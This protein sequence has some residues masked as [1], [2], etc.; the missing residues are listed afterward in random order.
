MN[1][2]LL[3]SAFFYLR[4]ILA[5]PQTIDI[6]NANIYLINLKHRKDKL[7]ASTVQ[8]EL[9]GLKFTVIDAVN[10]NYL[11]T[12]EYNENYPKQ[13]QSLTGI[14]G[15]KAD[16]NSIKFTPNT[17][18]HVGCWLSHL[19]A[20]KQILKQFDDR[21]SLILEDDFI[22]DGNVIELVNRYLAQL[23]KNHEWDL[24]H[25]G[26]CDS[27]EKCKYFLNENE[28]ICYTEERVFCT[29]AY[30]VKNKA[31]AKKL[32]N[33]GNRELPVLA[34]FFFE[35]AD[36]KRY[37]VFPHIFKQ[38]KNIEADIKSEGGIHEELL[39]NSLELIVNNL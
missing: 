12:F 17:P 29:H 1:S 27:K 24:L 34:D 11:N 8:L 3:L 21:I 26:H 20:L 16:L 18:A 32:F 7:Y 5:V 19:K 2:F 25:A 15:L 22:A 6:R 37:M 39:N 38:R 9:L 10:G 14:E 4:N 35:T 36:L 30:I 28:S 23:E 31:A 13:L 33:A